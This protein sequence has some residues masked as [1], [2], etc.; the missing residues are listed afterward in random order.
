MI[1]MEIP[2]EN[3][4]NGPNENHNP[5]DDIPSDLF[6]WHQSVSLDRAAPRLDVGVSVGVGVGVDGGDSRAQPRSECICS[7]W[8]LQSGSCMTFHASELSTIVC[9]LCAADDSI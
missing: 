8:T 2:G 5:L 7:R 6:V 4:M 1:L 3:R 9:W